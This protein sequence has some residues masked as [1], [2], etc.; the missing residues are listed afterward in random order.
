[1]TTIDLASVESRTRFMQISPEMGC[2]PHQVFK[3]IVLPH[4]TKSL[5]IVVKGVIDLMSS[6]SYIK[7]P[8]VAK[9]GSNDGVV[10][11]A[12]VY[13][14]TNNL[15]KEYVTPHIL[16]AYG[17][18]RCPGIL[19][20]IYQRFSRIIEGNR[21]QRFF[22]GWL[23]EFKNERLDAANGKWKK[24]IPYLPK[25][26]IN[27]KAWV[28]LIVKSG[29][30]STREFNPA[31]MYYEQAS[32]VNFDDVIGK[33]DTTSFMHILQQL[34]YTVLCFCDIELVHNDLHSKNVFVDEL[35]TP[36]TFVY[37]ISDSTFIVLSRVRW[38]ARIFDFDVATMPSKYGVNTSIAWMC[39]NYG[40]CSNFNPKFDLY[41]L[42]GVLVG[43]STRTRDF[44]E[45]LKEL[46]NRLF[47]IVSPANVDPFGMRYP[48]RFCHF[49][50]PP[51]VGT[52][53]WSRLNPDQERPKG[54]VK[55]T[56]KCDPTYIPTDE[57]VLHPLDFLIKI[58]SAEGT[59]HELS[60]VTPDVLAVVKEAVSARR[61][62]TRKTIDGTR[63]IRTVM[64]M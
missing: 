21:L 15:V 31:V 64:S 4:T 18:M 54:R 61:V 29:Y 47:R 10:Y 32:G 53:E 40:V 36:T 13:H 17:V 5:S 7:V 41:T 8:T 42:M 30:L 2:A 46:I 48:A 56:R 49:S 34:V 45:D 19:D 1:M 3:M 12:N 24:F 58:A 14:D 43:Y 22:D 38:F 37:F 27:D 57:E 52:D 35:V 11:E 62:F 20:F 9:I 44:P 59:L 51:A 16:V 39:E 50:Q 6:D 63:L 23:Q 28:E 26:G 60:S 55:D 33:L 25:D